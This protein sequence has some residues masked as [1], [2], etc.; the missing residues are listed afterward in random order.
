MREGGREGGREGRK[1]R[2]VRERRKRP[3]LLYIYVCQSIDSQ[4][5]RHCNIPYIIENRERG[6][7]Y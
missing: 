4:L 5:S 2:W 6:E 1:E 7:R 3:P